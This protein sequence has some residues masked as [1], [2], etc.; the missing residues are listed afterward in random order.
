MRMDLFPTNLAKSQKMASVGVRGF[1]KVKRRLGSETLLFLLILALLSL[2]VLIERSSLNAHER[3]LQTSLELSETPSAANGV[4]IYEGAKHADR[5]IYF[6][7]KGSLTERINDKSSIWIIFFSIQECP[8]C[9][10]F[11]PT[12]LDFQTKMM[13]V[14]F[15]APVRIG[16]MD[17]TNAEDECAVKGVS[18][19]PTVNL[20]TYGKLRGDLYT[21]EITSEKLL[22][23]VHKVND[24]VKR[25]R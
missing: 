19:Y 18:G 5:K 23:V 14:K 25:E 12:W 20:Y 16:K 4:Q 7:D 10:A 24:A 6:I 11:T 13:E 22:A 15:S 21:D 17:C 2:Y 9:Q 1:S 3:R 8:F